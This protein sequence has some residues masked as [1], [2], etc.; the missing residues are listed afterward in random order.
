M[1]CL[2]WVS[3]EER[4]PGWSWYGSRDLGSPCLGTTGQVWIYGSLLRPVNPHTCPI[5][6]EMAYSPARPLSAS[7]PM[8]AL[9]QL[10]AACSGTKVWLTVFPQSSPEP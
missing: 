8:T 6:A 2:G 9:A 7:A 4:L 1:L 3:G 5:R 10:Y